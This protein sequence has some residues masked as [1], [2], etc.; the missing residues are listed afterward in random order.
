MPQ[1]LFV[2]LVIVCDLLGSLPVA[3]AP[4]LDL[5][6]DGSLLVIGMSIA[7]SSEAEDAALLGYLPELERLIERSAVDAADYSTSGRRRS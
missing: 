1:S 6:E 2:D 4:E 7:R 3:D 5:V